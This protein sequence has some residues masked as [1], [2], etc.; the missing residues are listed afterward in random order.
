VA[1][2]VTLKVIHLLQ[3]FSHGIL[4]YSCATVDKILTHMDPL[5]EQRFLLILASFYFSLF[6]NTDKCMFETNES[7]VLEFSFSCNRNLVW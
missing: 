1:I 5:K 6:Y 2:Q 3:A 7:D 4:L